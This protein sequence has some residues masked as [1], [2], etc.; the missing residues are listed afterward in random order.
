V[1]DFTEGGITRHLISFAAPMLIGNIFQQFYSMADSIIVGNFISGKALAAVGASGTLL[2]FLLAILMGLTTGA[3]VV[4]SQY[5]GARR[6]DDLK[7][8]VSTSLVFLCGCGLVI[9]LIGV[10]FAPLFLRLMD[11]PEELMPDATAYLRIFVG[12]TLLPMVYNVYAAYLRALGDSRRP[13]Y[14]LI[15]SSVVNIGLDLL[16]VAVF[17]WGVP[18]VAWATLISQALASVA[19]YLYVHKEAV[20]LRID[21]LVFDHE[22]LRVIIKYSVPAAIQMSLTS[23][24]GLT[25][26]RLVNGFGADS[27]AGYSA[28]MRI[29]AFAMMPLSS[30]SMAISTFVGQN[31]GAGLED[32]AKKGLQIS[33]LLMVGLAVFVSGFIF[34]LGPS[35]VSLFVDASDPDAAAIISVGTVY[36]RT[37]SAFYVLFATFFAFNGFFRGVGDAVIVMALTIT[38]LTLRALSAY[39]LAGWANLG[40]QSVAFSIPVGWGLCSL[41]AWWWYAREKWRGKV[42]S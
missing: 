12:G 5:Y 41:F 40:V 7:R 14:F 28:S 38:S 18:G 42:A 37:L 13:L 24:A 4:I 20:M 39:A 30:I 17:H 2:N 34:L 16:F 10:I 26:M 33:M 36:L 9:T 35:L 8:T 11:T 3:S 19:I 31:M 15:F 6:Y 21:K 29:D 22:L 23:L 25:I 27:T 1:K 32:R